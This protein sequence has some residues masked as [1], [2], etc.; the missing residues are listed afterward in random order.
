MFEN[1]NWAFNKYK[2]KIDGFEE[3]FFGIIE[4]HN[5]YWNND[6]IAVELDIVSNKLYSIDEVDD[7]GEVIYICSNLSSDLNNIKYDLETLDGTVDELFEWGNSWKKLALRLIE[8]G[9]FDLNDYVE[10]MK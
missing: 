6:R 2:D 5:L 4:I 9:N 10:V 3:S 8:E 1:A 7:I